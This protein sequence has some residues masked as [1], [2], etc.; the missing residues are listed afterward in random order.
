[1]HKPRRYH[2]TASKSGQPSAMN[3][4][5]TNG[6]PA[7]QAPS[8]RAFRETYVVLRA[9]F[10]AFCQLCESSHACPLS[11]CPPMPPAAA[12]R[13]RR[14]APPRHH[15]A[16]ALSVCPSPVC[17]DQY[18]RTHMLLPKAGLGRGGMSCGG[19][20]LLL[21]PLLLIQTRAQQIDSQSAVAV[22]RAAGLTL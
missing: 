5:L 19:L 20:C 15:C 3:C 2:L 16:P 7:Q 21:L 9:C 4:R 6:D 11:A 22:L 10:A 17:T 14:Q 12:H 18:V 13:G 8:N 1:M